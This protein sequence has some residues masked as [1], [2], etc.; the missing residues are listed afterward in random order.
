MYMFNTFV[1]NKINLINNIKQVKLINP[2]SKIC[3]MVKANAY[4]VGLANVVKILDAYVDFFGVACF[5]EAEQ[6]LKL[7]NKKILIVG[8]LEKFKPTPL[9]SY[10]CSSL[11]DVLFLKKQNIQLN[12]HLKINSGMNRYGFK[13]LKEFNMALKEI[14]NSKLKL[15]GVY[16][17]YA[18][19]DDYV[20]K[21][22]NRF[23]KFLHLV[24]KYKFNPIVHAD[25]SSVNVKHNHHYNMVRIGYNLYNCNVRKFRRVVS[26][27]STITNINHVKKGELVGYNYK[28]VAKSNLKVGVIPIGYAD[29]FSLSNIGL[30]LR[31]GKNNCKV[32]NVCMDSFMIDLTQTKIKKGTS[33]QILGE[34]NSLS[35]YSSHLNI[36][37]YEVMCRFSNIRAKVKIN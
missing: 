27:Y 16:T 7:T 5:F 36:S 21:Q 9:V 6:V 18:T 17:H 25:N 37:E 23:A 15:E 33:I 13:Y 14:K 12:I 1:V 32:L 31:V 4:G 26:I 34:T 30:S 28:C 24:Y 29:G 2:N 19:D 22:N 20:V 11:K 10:T 3:A 35:N 8:P